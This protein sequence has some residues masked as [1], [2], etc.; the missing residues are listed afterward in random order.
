MINQKSIRT[1]HYLIKRDLI[2]KLNYQ[3]IN[4]IP[5]LYKAHINVGTKNEGLGSLA[6]NALLLELMSGRTARL[7]KCRTPS[8]Y[9]KM[10]K[11]APAG[12]ALS[13]KK[14]ELKKLLF[15]LLVEVTPNLKD[16]NFNLEKSA[17]QIS[18]TFKRD[19][20]TN[21]LEVK[22]LPD[23]FKNVKSIDFSITVKNGSNPLEPFLLL[24]P[25]LI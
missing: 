2:N 12:V 7:K 9:L 23:A 10:K 1:N 11:G 13:F 21:F 3:N 4:T 14:T 6:P 8:L 24:F 17:K 25:V 19:Q 18:F 22:Q 5:Y 15:N 16:F 20:I